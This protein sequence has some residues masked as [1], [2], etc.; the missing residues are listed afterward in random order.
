MIRKDKKAAGLWGDGPQAKSRKPA[1]PSQKNIQK[2]LRKNRSSRT[3]SS[4]PREDGEE[5]NALEEQTLKERIEYLKELSGKQGK[6]GKKSRK[7][8]VDIE[9][10]D[11]D[12]LI[13]RP[14]PMTMASTL[15]PIKDIRGG[16]I[17]TNDNRYIRIMEISPIN[18]Q[19]KAPIEQNKVTN[20]FESFLRI[21]PDNFQMKVLAKKTDI[22]FFT[23]K[24]MKTMRGRRTRTAGT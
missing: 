19:L 22:S 2:Q 10:L 16:M 17:I 6:D 4:R 9:N 7:D 24:W 14:I 15:Y 3:G 8:N 11:D 12:A 5:P 20:A 18:F 13:E 1:S 23:K 21:A